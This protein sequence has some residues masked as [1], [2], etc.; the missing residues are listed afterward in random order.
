MSSISDGWPRRSGR[1]PSLKKNK[2]RC[3]A[4]TSMYRQDDS[5]VYS[6]GV[7]RWDIA[8]KLHLARCRVSGDIFGVVWWCLR[9]CVWLV[10]R[11][12]HC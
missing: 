1:K 12:L 10:Y 4:G 9:R 8:S 2:K 11:G 3:D 5:Q 7:Q 6:L